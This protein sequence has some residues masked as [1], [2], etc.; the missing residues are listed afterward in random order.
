LEFEVKNAGA[1]L[2]YISDPN[3]VTNQ[4]II[5]QDMPAGKYIYQDNISNF[6]SGLYFANMK[7]NSQSQTCK[8]IKK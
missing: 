3:G 6:S 7:A 5:N 8:I 4:M 1:V 2:I